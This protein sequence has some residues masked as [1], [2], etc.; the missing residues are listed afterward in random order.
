MADSVDTTPSRI[1]PAHD[2]A[3]EPRCTRGET[4]DADDSAGAAED[5]GGTDSSHVDRVR[6]CSC[7]RTARPPLC[8]GSHD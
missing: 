6:L 7:G 3:R 8:D 4:T 1:E 2:R 5:E